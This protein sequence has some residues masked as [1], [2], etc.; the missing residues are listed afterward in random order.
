MKRSKMWSI[1]FF[2]LVVTDPLFPDL[3]QAQDEEEVAPLLQSFWTRQVEVIQD[4]AVEKRRALET[5]VSIGVIPNDAF[6]L[7][8]PLA[9]RLA[10][11]LT[12]QW[13]L[14]LSYEYN[15]SFD[16]DL[17]AFLEENDGALRATI[18]DRQTFRIDGGV[19]FSPLYGKL[20]LGR[21]VLCFDLFFDS[22]AG[23]V[24]TAEEKSIALAAAFRPDF[25]LGTG[26]RAF[27]GRR[28]VVRLEYRQFFF[29]RPKDEMGRGGGVGFPAEVAL[30]V[31]FFLGGRR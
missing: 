11:H 31:G 16:T 15:L 26:L 21:R 19:L 23:V 8:I 20:A 22:G 6:L 4:R 13:A 9:L 24:R 3:A 12:E 25:Y 27:L 2:L 28:W 7:Y 14:E 29:L 17:R 5:I 30:N 10:Y 18:R 1:I